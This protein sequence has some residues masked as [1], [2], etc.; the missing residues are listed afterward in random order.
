M[1]S[2]ALN[3]MEFRE[4]YI[5]LYYWCLKGTSLGLLGCIKLSLDTYSTS[6]ATMDVWLPWYTGMY[7]S[8]ASFMNDPIVGTVVNTGGVAVNTTGQAAG[9]E[10]NLMFNLKLHIMFNDFKLVS[11]T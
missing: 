7:G 9:I 11:L 8:F 10:L 6:M 5:H 1:I 2:V 3:L 4:L